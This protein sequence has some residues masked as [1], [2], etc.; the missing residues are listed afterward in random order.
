[1]SH[2]IGALKEKAFQAAKNLPLDPKKD[3]SKAVNIPIK[4]LPKPP[5]EK[6]KFKPSLIWSAERYKKGQ[7]RK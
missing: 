4:P 1:M 5:I 6:R 2:T 3:K 7:E